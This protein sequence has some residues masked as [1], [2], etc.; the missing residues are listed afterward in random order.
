MNIDVAKA[1]KELLFEHNTVILTGLGGFTSTPVNATVDYVQGAVQPPTRKVEFNSNLVIN[2]GVL[3]NYLQQSNLV[4]AQEASA[5]IE[6]YVAGIKES[7]EA[8]EIIDIPE[9]GRL[10]KDYEQKTR[11]MPDSTN[12]EIDSFGLSTVKLTPVARPKKEEESKT[13]TFKSTPSS[14]SPKKVATTTPTVA[15]SS[16]WAEKLLPMLIVI[17]AIL[18][19]FSLFV[20]LR[21]CGTQPIAEVPQ[22]RVNVKPKQEGSDGK[23]K[24]DEAEVVTSDPNENDAATEEEKTEEESVGDVTREEGASLPVT[25]IFVVVHSFGNRNNARKFAKKLEEG[26][27]LAATKKR[28][29][30]YRVG[31]EVPS[32]RQNEIGDLIAELG[33][34]FNAKPVVVDY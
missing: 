34:K 15:S 29:G 9:V 26:G 5:A 19:A 2:D 31:V 8:R 3:V 24:T 1:I 23:T 27:Y 14:P 4:T 17:A 10:Y 21:G 11:F 28:G 30:L 20:W 22:E 16:H 6:N 12:F 32:T 7:L 25:N 33:R 13:T 18:L